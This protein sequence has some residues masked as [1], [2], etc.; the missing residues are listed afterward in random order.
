MFD[1]RVLVIHLFRDSE[2]DDADVVDGCIAMLIDF[3]P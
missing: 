2:I 3:V 1:D